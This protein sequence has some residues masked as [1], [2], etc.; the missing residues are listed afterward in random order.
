M[1]SAVIISIL[2]LTPDVYVQAAGP[3]RCW[4]GNCRIEAKDGKVIMRCQRFCNYKKDC[5]S[6]CNL[7]SGK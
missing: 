2:I 1:I 7:R 6:V 4:K 5:H 3:K